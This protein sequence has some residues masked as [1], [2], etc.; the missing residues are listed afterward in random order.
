M[1]YNKY[2]LASIEA[3]KLLNEIST[4]NPEEAWDIATQKIFGKGTPSQTKPCPRST[5]LA[6]CETGRLKGIKPGIYTRSQKNKNYALYAINLLEENSKL[7]SNKKD[8]WHLIPGCENKTYNSQMDV[9]LSLWNSEYC[10]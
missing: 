9:V 1:T 3:V 4:L 5:F 10:I 2:G 7:A 8:L 6:M